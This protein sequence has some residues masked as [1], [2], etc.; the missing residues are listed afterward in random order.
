MNKDRDKVRSPDSFFFRLGN[1]I[2]DVKSVFSPESAIRS[3]EARR[4]YFGYEAAHE[5]RRDSPFPW[6]GPAEGMNKASRATLRARARDLERNNPITGSIIVAESNNVISTGFNMQARS[7]NEKFNARIEE[8]WEEWCHHENCDYTK[9]QCLDDLLELIA[10][11][12]LIDGGILI[13]FPLDMKRRIPLTIQLHEVDEMTSD[14]VPLKNGNII[15]DGVESTPEGI[16][17]AYWITQTDVDGFTIAE[18]KRLN[19]ED[20]IF[21]WKRTRVSQFREITPMSN[22]IIATKDTGDYNSAVNFQQKTAAC[23]SAFV[24]SEA[25]TGTL[26]RLAA[27]TNE[28][29]EGPRVEWLQG[30]SIKYL[31]P[32]EKIKPLIPTGQ[33]AEVGNYLPLQMRMISATQ[34]L[35]LESTSRNVERVNYSSARQNLLADETTYKRIRKRLVEYF[36]RPLFRRFVTVCY[37]SGLLD[38]TGF[39]INDQKYYKAVWLAPSLGWIDPNK[40]AQANTQNLQNGGKS[41]QQYCA[42]QGADWKERIDEMA[43]AQEYAKSKGVVLNFGNAIKEGEKNNADDKDED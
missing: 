10:R 30:G 18:P 1:L 21:I 3:K 22:S 35:S 29:K 43:E 9:Q 42:E 28:K 16:P 7:D 4:G 12:E 34:G 40:E 27:A 14:N 6:D 15:S 25:T 2:D 26:G 37:L 11:R 8:L 17:V 13:T 23:V 24:E 32:G 38:G 19:A 36:L 33:A 41:F 31:A 5:T 39:D 20:T